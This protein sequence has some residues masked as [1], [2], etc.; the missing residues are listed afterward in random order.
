MRKGKRRRKSNHQ[1]VEHLLPG[2]ENYPDTDITSATVQTARDTKHVI[3]VPSCCS[4]FLFLL[5]SGFCDHPRK[6][7]YLSIS[8]SAYILIS[9][10]S[11]QPRILLLECYRVDA[12]TQIEKLADLKNDYTYRKEK[13][14]HTSDSLKI[15]HS[16]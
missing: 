16:K 7:V 11:K 14:Q 13:K 3:C 8:I 15:Q 12:L 2:Q 10:V 4:L 5:S 9:R 1:T 6:N